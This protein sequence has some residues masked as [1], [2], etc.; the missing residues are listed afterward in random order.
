MKRLTRKQVD[1]WIAPI[2]HALIEMKSGETDS[3]RGYA[4]TKLREQEYSRTD[5]CIEGFV[6]MFR[7]VLPGFDVSPL[8]KIQKRLANGLPVTMDEIDAA[9]RFLRSTETPLIKA[10]WADIKDAIITEQIKIE[11]DEMGMAA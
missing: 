6:G 9:L 10:K 8:V 2:R 3:I 7:R 11:M 4:V 5:F 1:A